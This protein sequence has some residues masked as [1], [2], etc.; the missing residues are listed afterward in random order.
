M[1]L[2][3]LHPEVARRSCEA[4][5]ATLFDDSG[6]QLIGL[7]G[8]PRKRPSG[9][10]TPCRLRTGCP[11][12]TP[13]QQNSHTPENAAV[14]AHWRECKA[15][16]EFPKDSL[17]RQN[18]TAIEMALETVREVKHARDQLRAA[19]LQWEMRSKRPSSN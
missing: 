13:E 7:D 9:V 11:K 14:Y 5:Q 10:P 3:E 6:K 8:Q 19:S 15:V 16:G 12:G 1:L 2:A 4:C 18:A 17:V